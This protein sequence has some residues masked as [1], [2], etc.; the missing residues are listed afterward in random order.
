MS[1][2]KLGNKSTLKRAFIE[3]DVIAFAKHF[4]DNNPIH[5]D[6]QYAKSSIFKRVI[7]HGSLVSSLFS[8]FLANVKFTGRGNEYV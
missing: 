7:V 6:H 5:L 8:A 3:D 4:S 1:I 2:W